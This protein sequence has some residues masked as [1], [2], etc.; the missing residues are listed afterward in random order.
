[1]FSGLF[2]ADNPGNFES[3]DFIKI[4]YRFDGAGAFSELFWFSANGEAG[5]DNDELAVDN[6]ANGTVDGATLTL[7]AASFS[8]AIPGTGSTLDVRILMASSDNTEA[9]AFDSI[10]V[11]ATAVPEPGA[12]LFGCVV[13]GAVGLTVARRKVFGVSA[14][15]DAT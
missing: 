10:S 4:Q 14:V 5:S 6:D 13:C 8:K 2:A 15:Q 9:I 11:T 7:A 3:T 12:V 1:M